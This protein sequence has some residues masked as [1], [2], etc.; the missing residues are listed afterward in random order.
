VK[1]ESHLEGLKSQF[2]QEKSTKDELAKKLALVRE[3][4]LDRSQVRGAAKLE[5]IKGHR[6]T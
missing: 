2:S 6:T 3:L 5:A 4:L 1:T